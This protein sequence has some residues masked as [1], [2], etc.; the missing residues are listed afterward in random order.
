M[1]SDNYADNDY[2]RGNTYRSRGGSIESA[3]LNGANSTD[4]Q[5]GERPLTVEQKHRSGSSGSSGKKRR[6]KKKKSKINK[7][8]ILFAIAVLAAIFFCL[9]LFFIIENEDVD[10]Y[11]SPLDDLSY[12]EYST[13]N[14]FITISTELT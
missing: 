12:I 7:Y 10:V 9:A 3:Y 8:L 14:G 13:T 1:A 11:T 4:D 6:R 5:T 2:S